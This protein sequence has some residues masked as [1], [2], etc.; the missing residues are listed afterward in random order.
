[1]QVNWN[2]GITEPGSSGS[3]LFSNTGHY[4]IGQLYGGTTSCTATSGSDFFGR[5]DLAYTAGLSKYL[6]ATG[7]G[8]APSGPTPSLD[9]SAL[10]WNPSESGWGMSITQHDS[11]LFAAWFVYGPSGAPTWVIMSGGTWTTPTSITGTLYSTTGPASTGTFDPSQVKLTAVGS[12][13][14]TFSTQTQAVLSYTVSGISGTKAIQRQDFGT[15]AATT[16]ASYADL[17][18][19]ASESGWGI[20]VNQQY[21]TLFSVIYAYGQYGQP[22]WYVMPGGAWTGSTTYSGTLYQTSMPAFDYYA[23]AFNTANV[24]TQP[25]GTISL[26]FTSTS[27]ATLTYTV[28][29]QSFTKAI[30]REA[31]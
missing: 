11:R 27:T 6:A 21:N 2:S 5:F 23:T 25:V 3:A 26:Q 19:T 18:W 30:T 20:S 13:T 12:A 24:T 9:Y 1:M 7:S 28:N 10:W 31:F 15:S 29:G 4:V 8:S 17:W 22:V 14:I 16:V